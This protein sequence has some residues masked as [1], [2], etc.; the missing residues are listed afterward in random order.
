[1]LGWPLARS[2]RNPASG[3]LAIADIPHLTD[4]KSVKSGMS[5]REIL[6]P[7]PAQ[8]ELLLR[9]GYDAKT[10]HLYWLARCECGFKSSEDAARWNRKYVGKRCFTT[11]GSGGAKYGKFLGVQYAAHRIIWKMVTG[12]D[13]EHIDHINGNPSDNRWENLRSVP[14][15]DNLRNR[16][17]PGNNTSGHIGVYY[18]EWSGK[19][20]AIIYDRGEKVHLGYFT[21]KDEAIAARQKAEKQYGYHENHG[22]QK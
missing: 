22:R 9:I 10:G 13:P 2:D 11:N 8:R 4:A 21:Q 5:W 14:P 20:I 3:A 16:A 17:M 15:V 1:M 19:W 12:E 18:E 7:L 6:K